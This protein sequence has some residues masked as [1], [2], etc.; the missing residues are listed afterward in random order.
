MKK[1]FIFL[2]AYFFCAYAIDDLVETNYEAEIELA[3]KSACFFIKHT[4]SGCIIGRPNK[5]V[6]KLTTCDHNHHDELDLSRNLE[7]D[8]ISMFCIYDQDKKMLGLPFII[9]EYSQAEYKTV[10]ESIFNTL[11]PAIQPKAVYG[12][13]TMNKGKPVLSFYDKSKLWIM[14]CSGISP[15]FFTA[16]KKKLE[17]S[18]VGKQQ[19]GNSLDVSGL[20]S[21]E[22]KT[23]GAFI[24]RRFSWDVLN[25]IG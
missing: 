8:T 11:N 13:I 18:Q 17:L 19:I 15:A 24:P 7:N 25:L 23:N 16:S 14:D 4:K 3:R 21:I 1:N 6:R 5:Q 9:A 2:I 22:N 10:C 20:Q 12:E